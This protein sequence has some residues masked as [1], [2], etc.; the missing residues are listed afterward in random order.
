MRNHINNSFSPAKRI[1]QIFFSFLI[2]LVCMFGANPPEASNDHILNIVK[3]AREGDDESFATLFELYYLPICRHLYRMVANEDDASDLAAETFT[4][5]WYRLSRI[6]DEKNFRSWLYKIATNAA[7]DYIRTN[8]TQKRG[9][10]PVESLSED[11]ANEH[12]LRFEDQV[13]EQELLKLALEEVA[14]KPRACFLLYEEGLNQEEIA[15]IMGMRKKSVGTYI[16][17]AREQLRKAYD[18]LKNL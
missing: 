10:R 4:R 11:F 15:E 1:L 17:I 7:L 8:S 16:S 14:P 13:E 6:H 9:S 5:A 3:R 12:A 18:R 2:L